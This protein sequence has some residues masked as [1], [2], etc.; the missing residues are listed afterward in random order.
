MHY[1]DKETKKK[2][3]KFTE[4]YFWTMKNNPSALSTLHTHSHYNTHTLTHSLTHT[5][6]YDTHSDTHNK[7]KKKKKIVFC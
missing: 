6:I 7:I 4:N 5:Y 2:K 3:T 1:I